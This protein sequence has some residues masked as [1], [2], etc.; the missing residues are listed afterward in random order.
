MYDVY[1]LK[2]AG[3]ETN[4]DFMG[5]PVTVMASLTPAAEIS[6]ANPSNVHNR[7]LKTVC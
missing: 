6:S 7:P 1:C 3:V 5:F 4:L 2:D